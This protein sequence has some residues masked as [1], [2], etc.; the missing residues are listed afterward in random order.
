[1]V[2]K[3]KELISVLNDASSLYYNS[4]NSPLSDIEFDNK[5]KELQALE[6][7]SGV[8]LSNSPTINVGAPV[9][10]SMKKVDILYRPMLSL[11]KVHSE[12]E[13]DAF[14]KG[15]AILGMIKVDGLS[16]RL[17]YEN[18]KLKSANTRGNGYV[19]NDITEHIKYFTNVP[20]QI[21]HSS[22]L[23]VDGEAIIKTNDFEIINTNKELK[24]PRN[25]AAGTLNLLDMK[26]V[27]RRKL[28]FIAWDS[29]SLPYDEFTT[30]L[31]T[32]ELLGFEVVFH[33]FARDNNL[34]MEKAKELNIPCDGV[35][36]KYNNVDYGN[37]LGQTS[38]HFLN[39]IAW[40]P[41]DEVYTT[42]LLDIDWTMGRVGVLT[43][44]A[45]FSPVEMDGSV[46]ERA[47]LH[48]LTI[49]EN[50]LGE[51]YFDQELEIFKANMIIPQVK[52][53]I[54]L[55]HLR[56]D[57]LKAAFIIPENCPC[58]GGPLSRITENSSTVLKCENKDCSGQLIN[59]LDHFCGKKGLDIRG[60]SKATLEKL[61][62]WNWINNIVDIFNLKQYEKEWINK[63]GFGSKSVSNILQAIENSK[64]CDLDKFICALGIPLIGTTAAKDLAKF[65]HSW[66]ELYNAVCT[67]FKFY[68][69]PNFGEEMH[70]SII[71]FDYSFANNLINNYLI[72]KEYQE[73]NN[74]NKT[75]ENKNIVITGRLS[76]SKNRAELKQRIESAGGKVIEAVSKN[77]NY[78]IN[79]DIN[80]T[81]SK[82]LTAKKLNIP[83]LTEEEFIAQFLDF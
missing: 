10:D 8:I 38:H 18:G 16:V 40:K 6:K 61:I 42:N 54:K 69:L 50:I 57:G 52:S 37:S 56:Q 53:A 45:V 30:N 48:N 58:C 4:G 35:V 27:A 68:T 65:F 81:S 41:E 51:P 83:I 80:S 62:E 34:I 75:L 74:I 60:L 67:E 55:E 39:G 49:M 23:V 13:I 17:I 11:D 9:L 1:M 76:V 31:S 28:S 44:V 82:N 63:P 32:L 79:N 64:E 73:N 20:L 19:G 72:I 3:M 36:W 24:N 66:A 12:E 59:Q 5:L 43:P 70:K 33:T 15:H 47:N 71:N 7:Q 22:L 14:A 26:E 46:V 25:A 77:T 29:P 2:S 78:L 21:M